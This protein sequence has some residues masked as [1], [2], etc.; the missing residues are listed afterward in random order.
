MSDKRDKRHPEN[1]A[2]QN[3]A[4]AF[5]EVG[6][7]DFDNSPPLERASSNNELPEFE[8]FTDE[9]Y[10]DVENMG[11]A[12]YKIFVS[13][14]NA[15]E[16]GRAGLKAGLTMDNIAEAGETLA[17]VKA[18]PMG[19]GIVKHPVRFIVF[20]ARK[21]VTEWIESSATSLPKAVAALKASK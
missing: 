19:Y 13:C 21:V 9:A 4:R 1:I 16:L 14:K 18:L 15:Y 12:E 10:F 2:L 17:A 7:V 6:S 11:D 20:Q 5:A 8:E 3:A